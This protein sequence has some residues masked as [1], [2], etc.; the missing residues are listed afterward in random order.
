MAT[1]KDRTLERLAHQ[2]PAIAELLSDPF[3]THGKGGVPELPAQP[4]P[5]AGPDPNPETPPT[6]PR[7]PGRPRGSK[8]R[9]T[10]LDPLTA[11]VYAT[12]DRSEC[13]G[14]I[15]GRTKGQL[16]VITGLAL[17][18]IPIIEEGRTW[19]YRHVFEESRERGALIKLEPATVR[20]VPE[21]WTQT[22]PAQPAPRPR[23]PRPPS[24]GPIEAA[25]LPDLAWD[26]LRSHDLDI[27]AALDDR[28]L[29]KLRA[30]VLT[31]IRVLNICDGGGSLR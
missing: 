20:T 25:P 26:I 29:R 11:I 2:E 6:P 19:V 23:K 21:E 28:D 14:D 18:S 5:S 10:G 1:K 12:T 22:P 7:K 24:A 27:S 16:I 3:L 4:D 8:T 31:M 30:T 9:R 15:V 17:V 13:G